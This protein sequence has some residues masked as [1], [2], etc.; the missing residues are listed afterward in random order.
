MFVRHSA[1]GNI[2]FIIRIDSI[3]VDMHNSCHDKLFVVI[4]DSGGNSNTNAF[5]IVILLCCFMMTIV[6]PYILCNVI[7]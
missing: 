7:I 3:E 5:E 6:M 1:T 2:D 4:T